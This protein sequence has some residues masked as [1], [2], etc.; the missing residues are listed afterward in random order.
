MRF[1]I[2]GG[3]L[4]HLLGAER[5]A[6]LRAVGLQQRRLIGYIHLGAAAGHGKFQVHLHG[7]T[8]VNLHRAGNVAK[9]GAVTSTR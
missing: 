2:Q 5:G 6:D 4:V 1:A 9:P 8:D 7:G 3:Q